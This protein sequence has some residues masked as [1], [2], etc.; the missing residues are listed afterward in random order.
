[1]LKLMNPTRAKLLDFIKENPD[2]TYVQMR[3]YLGNVSNG[4]VDFHV[5]TLMAKGF[6][7]RTRGFKVKKKV[8]APYYE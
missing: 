6:I 2:A 3:E 4:H 8:T 7:E 1:M 5:K